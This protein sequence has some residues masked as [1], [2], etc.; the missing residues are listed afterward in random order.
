VG[1]RG[2]YRLRCFYW[3]H[4]MRF[5]RQFRDLCGWISKAYASWTRSAQIEM[6]T[7]GEMAT[8][9][10]TLEETTALTN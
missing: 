4:V 2:R 3:R 5:R 6:G 7:G 1:L 9:F 8:A 10:G